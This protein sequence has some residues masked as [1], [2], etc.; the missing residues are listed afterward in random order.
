MIIDFH[1]H[2]FPP[3]IAAGALTK[4]QGDSHARAF[5]DGTADGLKASM[6]NAGVDCSVVLPVATNP[7]K[8]AS[9]NDV[10]IAAMGQGSLLYFGCIHPAMENPRRELERLAA[11]G[12]KG[13]KIHPVYQ[14]AD[15]N[16]RPY[17][18]ILEAAGELGLIVVT[19]AGDDIA[20]PGVVRCSPAML[21]DA[22]DRV[23]P[24]KLVA[25][26]MGGWKNWQQVADKL[27]GTGVYL[28][29]AF[30][31]GEIFPLEPEYFTAETRQLLS[32]EAFCALVQ[33]FGAERVL[34]GTDSPWADQAASIAAIASL[35]L[36]DADKA[37]IFSENACALL[38]LD[39]ATN[40]AQ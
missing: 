15:I 6:K 30:A 1:T 5:L 38:A 2:T 23:G 12:I 24:V 8:V 28:D 25:A 11:A 29:T 36:K 22:L 18:D 10:S 31:L 19:H 37:R 35:P 14:N 4:M 33:A 40:G 17:L 20:F 21:R 39:V 3:R 27:A 34:F 9:I 26:H 13:I 32:Q 7:Q 16:S